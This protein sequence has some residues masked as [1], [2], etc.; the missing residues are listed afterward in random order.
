MIAYEEILMQIKIYDD[1]YID[2]NNEFFEGGEGKL[3][4]Y[5]DFCQQF[6][7]TEEGDQKRIGPT[8]PVDLGP[9]CFTT[10]KPL[11]FV[12]EKYNDTYNMTSYRDDNDLLEKIQSGKGDQDIYTN[13]V[14]LYPNL[15]FFDTV[16]K[17]ID[18]NVQTGK[19]NIEFARATQWAY[20]IDEGRNQNYTD[21]MYLVWE[22][23]AEEAAIEFNKESK[24]IRIQ[25]LTANG[26]RE[27]FLVGVKDD[28]VLI[29]IATFLVGGYTILFLGSCSP[30]HCRALSSLVGLLCIGI[31]YFSGFG[32]MFIFGGE[33]AGVHNL[34]PFLLIGIG[35]DDMFVIANAVDQL[36]FSHSAADRLAIAMKHA[37]PSISITSLTNALAF[38]FGSTTSLIALRSFCQFACCCVLMLYITVI[39]IFVPAMIWDTKRVESKKADCMGLCCCTEDSTICCKGKFLSDK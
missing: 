32:I 4:S 15:F 5:K 28:L 8:D 39:F 31:S 21:S 16:P 9:K 26:I 35:V 17:E 7:Y 24:H 22:K 10:Q 12:Y 13:F 33:V 37:G 14:N 38:F 18:Q 3:I 2:D 25:L 11:D 27:A 34:M 30:I 36:P 23:F 29:Q 1:A 20:F 19:N 6:N